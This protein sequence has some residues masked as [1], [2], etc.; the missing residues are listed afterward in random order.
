VECEL[1]SVRYPHPVDDRPGTPM[2]LISETETQTN[3][4]TP[5]P[6]NS[7]FISRIEISGGADGTYP[8]T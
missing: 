8:G 2:A 7:F 3:H 1:Q 6:L 5:D 4:R